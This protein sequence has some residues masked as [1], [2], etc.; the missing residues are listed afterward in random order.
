M[1]LVILLWL[2]HSLSVLVLFDCLATALLSVT[3]VP[4]CVTLRV[5]ANKLM[6]HCCLK[7]KIVDA[8]I[9]MQLPHP[10]LSLLIICQTASYKFI[11]SIVF[12]RKPVSLASTTFSLLL[13]NIK[14]INIFYMKWIKTV[15]LLFVVQL[16]TPPVIAFLFF[17]FFISFWSHC[18]QERHFVLYLLHYPILN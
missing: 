14:W 1:E 16:D 9:L 17:F 11:I 12:I 6:F 4:L 13:C 18:C 10:A 7:A 5:T 3:V 2:Y 8:V 15:L